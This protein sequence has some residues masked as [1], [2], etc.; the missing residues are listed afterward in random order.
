L[1][2]QQFFD[3]LD[4]S[5]ALT[6]SAIIPVGR[7]HMNR[8]EFVFNSYQARKFWLQ[9]LYNYGKFYS[10]RIKT[11]SSSIGINF[12]KHL[13]LSTDYSYNIVN[14]P[15]I[16]VI[17]HQLDQYINYALSTKFDISLFAQWNSLEDIM[18]YNFRLHWIPRIGSDFYH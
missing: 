8:T 5:F 4:N 14:L 11:F 10:G 1:N 7:Y 18:L 16:S 17:T 13:N 6:D 3:R 9:L 12:S 2:L 15:R